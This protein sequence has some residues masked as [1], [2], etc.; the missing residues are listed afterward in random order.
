MPSSAGT[1]AGA[2]MEISVSKSDLLKETHRDTGRGGTQNHD[3]NPLQFS[4]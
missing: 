2:T 4:V 1:E 3:S